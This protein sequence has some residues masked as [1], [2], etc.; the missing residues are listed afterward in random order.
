MDYKFKF[1]DL[2]SG[3][4]GFRIGLEKCGG[5][6][7]FTCEKD[8]NAV[9]TYKANFDWSNHIIIEKCRKLSKQS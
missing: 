7:V 9:A 2:F 3:I 4:G 5:K 1:I 6:C 8:A